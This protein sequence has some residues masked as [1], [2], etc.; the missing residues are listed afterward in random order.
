MF[1]SL[2]SN[3]NNALWS[4]FFLPGLLCCGLLL[5]LRC[6]ALQLRHFSLCMR[7]SIG[8]AFLKKEGGGEG[9]SSFQAAS[10]ALAS[11]VGTGNI[12]GTAQALCLG[13]AGAV[14][15]MWAASFIGMIVKFSEICLSTYFK[16]TRPESGGG[17]MAYI[18]AAFGRLGPPLAA[19]YA[20]FAALAGL[21]MGNMTQ[22]NS[23]AASLVGAAEYL[24]LAG[25]GEKGLRLILGICLGAL[26]FIILSGGARG[27]GRAASLLVPVM[28]LGFILLSLGVLCC[29]GQRLPGILVYI[30]SEAFTPRAALGG[31]AGIA[32][33]SAIGW[34]LRRSAFSNEAGLGT[35]AIAHS[36]SRGSSPVEE[37]FWGVFEVFADT[38]LLCTL[39]ALV[40]LC[41]GSS[42]PYGSSAGAELL[43][44]AFATVY[45]R[46][47]SLVFVAL[48]MVL[49]AFSSVLGWSLY[50]LRCWEYLFGKGSGTLYRLIFSA[51][52][53]PGAL[54]SA[55]LVWSLSDLLNVLMSV[56]N[57]IA[58]LLLSGKVGRLT[59]EYVNNQIC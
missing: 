58:L 47:F 15:W 32:S 24:P 3:V 52:A 1:K 48:T 11:T 36:F 2:V 23:A 26:C 4:G 12:V 8:R 5:T 7:G 54:V 18:R 16:N 40:I 27:I 49:L 46:G 37:G 10:T 50:G 51:A 38:T 44:A 59:G 19:A 17:P 9:I 31:S 13:G 33:A 6:G 22:I 39:T 45:G 25:F 55:E 42:I 14:F 57:L 21:G 56:P 35:S 29:H 34:G 41:S 20:F 43:C 28:S 53:I 30:T